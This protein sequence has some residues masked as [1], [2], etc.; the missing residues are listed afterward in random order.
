MAAHYSEAC[1]GLAS[2]VAGLNDSSWAVTVQA[3]ARGRGG[4]VG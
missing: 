2:G 3:E 4:V 1:T